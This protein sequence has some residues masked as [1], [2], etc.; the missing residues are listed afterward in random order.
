MSAQTVNS[1]WKTV[2]SMPFTHCCPPIVINNDEFM[3]ASNFNGTGVYKFNIHKNKW[4]KIFYYNETFKCSVV[5]TAY[6]HKNKLL[7]AHNSPLNMVIFDLNTEHKATLKEEQCKRHSEL[8]FVSDKL[9]QI[10][11]QSGNHYV[12]DKTKQFQKITTF[13]YFKGLQNYGLIFL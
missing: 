6:D 11:T 2:E 8:I 10:C 9:H 5:S 1:I 12:Y 7:Y 13:N 4:I 3:V